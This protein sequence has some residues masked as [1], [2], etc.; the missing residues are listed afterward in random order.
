MRK[1]IDKH[2]NFHR[3][4]FWAVTTLFVFVIFFHISDALEISRTSEENTPGTVKTPFDY[5]FVSNLIRYIVLYL[6]FLFLSFIVVPK[7][8]R[9]ENVLLNILFIA[10]AL[11]V[12]SIVFGITNTYLKYNMVA[13]YRTDA[14]THNSL[15]QNGFLYSLWLLLM[16]GFYTVIKYIGLHLLSESE[17]LQARFKFVT[18]AGIVGFI[19]WMIGLFV[20]IVSEAPKDVL[21]AAVIIPPSII[22]LYWF[23]FHY[24]IPL[25]LRKKNPIRAYALRII[26]V[27]FFGSI[28]LGIIAMIIAF[29]E[30]SGAALATFNFFF[31]LLIIAPICWIAFKRKMKGNEELYFL[32]KELGQTH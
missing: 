26:P 20:L 29:D 27:L 14:Y 8:L 22:L 24:L 17:T 25:S 11:I 32:K 16:F 12:T 19:V 3:V 1:F 23:T 30:D 6:G 10:L 13:G 28:P 9:R 31:Q 21:A 7:L 4:E 15:L 5:H 2:I 18:H